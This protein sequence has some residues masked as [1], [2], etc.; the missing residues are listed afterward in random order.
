MSLEFGCVAYVIL[1]LLKRLTMRIYLTS[2]NVYIKT[3]VEF[4]ISKIKIPERNVQ[5]HQ[6]QK[7]HRYT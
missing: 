4:N 6:C 3:G 2:H 7:F 1:I 5:I